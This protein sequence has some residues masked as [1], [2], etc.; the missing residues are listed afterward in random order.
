[1]GD[2]SRMRRSRCRRVKSASACTEESD[3][4]Q[5][6]SHESCERL[7]ICEQEMQGAA[8]PQDTN[9]VAWPQAKHG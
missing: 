9:C 2:S 3:S 4:L 8:L 1:M 6:R 7:D 5:A